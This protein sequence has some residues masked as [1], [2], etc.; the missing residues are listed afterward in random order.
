MS[1]FGSL[2]GV[3][4]AASLEP[5]PDTHGGM[6]LAGGGR[7]KLNPR[8]SEKIARKHEHP[9]R[10]SATFMLSTAFPGTFCLTRWPLSR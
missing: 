1:F 10:D 4:C 2:I 5:I 3:R 9:K 8:N 7:M 6:L